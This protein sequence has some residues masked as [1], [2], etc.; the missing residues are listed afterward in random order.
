MAVPV[1]VD[2]TDPRIKYSGKFGSTTVG[3]IRVNATTHRAVTNGSTISFSFNGTAVAWIAA[4]PGPPD[5]DGQPSVVEFVVDDDPETASTV[6]AP[7]PISVEHRATVY[8]SPPLPSGEHKI[9]VTMLDAHGDNLWFDFLEYTPDDDEDLSS[10]PATTMT[11]SA[12]Q[13]TS[14]TTQDILSAVQTPSSPLSATDAPPESNLHPSLPPTTSTTSRS[15][16]QPSSPAQ[17]PKKTG[18]E[19]TILAAALGSC[20]GVLLVFLAIVAWKRRQ[21]QRKD[22]QLDTHVDPFKP[23]DGF[24]GGLGRETAP[25]APPSVH[26]GESEARAVEYESRSG[27]PPPSYATL[28]P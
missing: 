25:P 9:V 28:P 4:I 21:K 18:K 23:E 6:I 10:S 27:G 24:R 19:T 26:L 1:Q 11:S 15:R 13:A 14:S 16:Q 5:S 20:A 3:N 17:L 2:D 12:V 8:S 7:H 22:Q